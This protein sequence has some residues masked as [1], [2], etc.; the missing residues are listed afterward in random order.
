MQFPP[1]DNTM[2]LPAIQDNHYNPRKNIDYVQLILPGIL[3]G[4]T[5]VIILSLS[6]TLL[7]D[8]I[9]DRKYYTESTCWSSSL[10]ETQNRCCKTTKCSCTDCLGSLSCSNLVSQPLNSSSCCGGSCCAGWC[11]DQCCSTTCTDGK[12]CRTTCHTCNEHCCA[13]VDSETCQFTCGTC[14]SFEIRF[15]LRYNNHMYIAIESCGQDDTSCVQ[16][17]NRK[18]SPGNS[19]KCWYDSRDPSK[20][21]F[22]GMP[23]LNVGVIVGICLVGVFWIIGCVW[24]CVICFSTFK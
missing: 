6:L 18:Y 22:N 16:N 15:T 14:Y 3:L 24:C 2:D 13:E 10:N 19:W 4:V 5:T 21:R 8:N 7:R 23:D 9:D 12:N 17:I 11:S 20:V 1:I